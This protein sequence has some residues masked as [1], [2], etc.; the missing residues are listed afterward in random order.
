M[1][2]SPGSLRV[3]VLVGIALVFLA[4]AAL[5]PVID[6]VAL[7]TRLAVA[8]QSVISYRFA[9]LSYVAQNGT[10]PNE[11]FQTTEEPRSV[12]E[13]QATLVEPTPPKAQSASL[14]DALLEAKRID[15]VSFPLGEKY[16]LP[17]GLGSWVAT[18]PEIWAVSLAAVAQHFENTRLFPSARSDKVAVL[19]V[20]FL[21]ER[22][23]QG[24]QKMVSNLREQTQDGVVFTG[25][26]FFTPSPVEG[27]F[28]GWLYLSDL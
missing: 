8:Q 22:E 7:N 18:R 26:C 16:T 21:S 11:L 23:A 12:E 27:K 20:P 25:D 14:G 5:R 13:E 1:D 28:T 17:E 3:W 2:L 4:L 10:V 6:L 15:R 9:V 24:I 19:V